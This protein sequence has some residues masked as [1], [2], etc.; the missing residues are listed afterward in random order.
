V[1]KKL[2]PDDVSIRVLKN[3]G[4]ENRAEFG[5]GRSSG[6]ESEQRRWSW[7]KESVI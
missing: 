4:K 3:E 1:K 6:G 5:R 7:I 2:K